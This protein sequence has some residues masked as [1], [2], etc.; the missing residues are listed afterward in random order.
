MKIISVRKGFTADHSST[1]YEFLA[2]DEPLNQEE[3]NKVSS[4]SS[5]ANPDNRAVKF[6]YNGDFNDLPGGWWPLMEKHYDILYSES[7]DWWLFAVAFSDSE[8]Q[9]E[10]SRYAFDGLEDLGV[11][12]DIIEDRIIV[13]FSCV[14]EYGEA[15]EILD[16]NTNNYGYKNKEYE[17][18]DYLNDDPL[19]QL[20][21]DIRNQLMDRDYRVFDVFWH[22]YGEP[23]YSQEEIEELD[24][25]YSN[26]FDYDSLPDNLQYLSR[27]LRRV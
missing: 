23:L 24:L 9:Q 12:I 8:N 17:L 20:L 21:S 18:E 2:I 5:R 15:Y 4:L 19:F 26:E 11:N 25:P 3:I 16:S 10:I 7:Y 6:A 1:S 22:E 13:S 27:I 14:L